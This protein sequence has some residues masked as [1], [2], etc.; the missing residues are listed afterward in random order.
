MSIL[1]R[2]WCLGGR[3]AKY[4]AAILRGIS[5]VYSDRDGF[6]FEIDLEEADPKEDEAAKF[7]RL[8]LDRTDA[9]KLLEQLQKALS[10]PDKV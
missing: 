3:K 8:R 2:S 9:T 4:I 7:M 6:T 10:S 1:V 5:K